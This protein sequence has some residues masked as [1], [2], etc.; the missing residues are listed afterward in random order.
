[1]SEPREYTF[2]D[3]RHL[4][5]TGH[6]YVISGSGRNRK[7]GYR[8]GVKCKLGDIETD[9]WIGLMEDLILRSGEE[10]IQENLVEWVSHYPWIKSKI[11]TKKEALI[12]HSC[13]LFDNELWV[14]YLLF[15]HQYRPEILQNVKTCMIITSCCNMPREITLARE[16]H[17][18]SFNGGEKT[19]PCPICG[20]WSTYKIMKAQ[21][22]E[23]SPE[24][25]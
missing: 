21:S 13:R 8:T 14:D 11:G 17:G 10:K 12:L 19:L 1:M 5:N 15:N 23:N 9:K 16:Q 3:L 25:P 22:K 7:M 20:R 4:L 18:Y 6:S 24:L 2:E